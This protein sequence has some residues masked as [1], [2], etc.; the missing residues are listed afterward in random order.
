VIA[1]IEQNPEWLQALGRRTG[2]PHLLR[3]DPKLAIAA[4][5]VQSAH[6]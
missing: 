6:Q 2:A 4:G 3:A 5:H 1:R